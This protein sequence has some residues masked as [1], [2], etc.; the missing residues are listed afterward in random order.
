MTMSLVGCFWEN[1]YI[2][3][4]WVGILVWQENGRG[5]QSGQG[6]LTFLCDYYI[7]SCATEQ[8]QFLGQNAIETDLEKQSCLSPTFKETI[9]SFAD[10][11]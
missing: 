1:N 9:P 5:S 2:R 4:N 3:S 6:F 8:N 11:T 10:K 7:L